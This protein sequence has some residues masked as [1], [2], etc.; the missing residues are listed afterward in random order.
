MKTSEK[1][2]EIST[3]INSTVQNVDNVLERIVK[4]PKYKKIANNYLTI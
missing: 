4:K 1:F 3:Q 2:Y